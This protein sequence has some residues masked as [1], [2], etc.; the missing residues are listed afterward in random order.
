MNRLYTVFLT[1]VLALVCSTGASAGAPLNLTLNCD[2]AN[3][4]EW[5]ETWNDADWKLLD[6][7]ANALS[8]T[9]DYGYQ[10]QIRP[11]E[12]MRID[13]MESANP[14]AYA[15]ISI[16]SP[17]DRNSLYPTESWE[18]R[19]Y[20]MRT[21]DLST[22]RTTKVV[23]NITDDPA[24][25]TVIRNQGA[26]FSFTEVGENYLALDP[27]TELPV[28]FSANGGIPLY[29]IELDGSPVPLDAN[30]TTNYTFKELT[31]GQKIDITANWPDNL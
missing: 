21:T 3:A 29:K 24:R 2:R 12:G 5:R 11:V 15:D 18:G 28:R 19:I 17:L 30:S 26:S 25:F 8:L 4:I 7:G 6:E 22:V 14:E 20:N 31:D 9:Y 10:L 16:Y 23:V 1:V 13:A 27:L